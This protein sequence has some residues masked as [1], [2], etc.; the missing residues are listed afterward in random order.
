MFVEVAI[1][2]GINGILH[3][4]VPTTRSKLAELGLISIPN[5]IALQKEKN[6]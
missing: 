3:T 6:D 4:D 2:L 5:E 1:S